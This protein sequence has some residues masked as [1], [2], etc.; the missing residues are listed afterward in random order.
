MKKLIFIFILLLSLFVFAEQDF[1]SMYLDS[2]EN[3]YNGSDAKLVEKFFNILTNYDSN[4]YEPYYYFA[5]TLHNLKQTKDAIPFIGRAVELNPVEETYYLYAKMLFEFDDK[6]FYQ[7]INTALSAYPVSEN[8][9]ALKLDY[10]NSKNMVDSAYSYA[11]FI[12][13]RIPNDRGALY[14]L[15]KYESKMENYTLAVSYLTQ[16]LSLKEPKNEDYLLAGKIYTASKN[17]IAANKSYLKLIASPYR[18]YSLHKLSDNYFT[19]ES[20]DSTLVMLDSLVKHYPDSVSPYGKMLAVFSKTKSEALLESLFIRISKNNISDSTLLDNLSQQ[21]FKYDKFNQAIE[22]YERLSEKYPAYCSKEF[23]QSY[24]FIK[25]YE[26]S[27]KILSV[28]PLK[29]KVDSLFVFKYS[30]LNFF[31]QGKMDSSEF[32][33]ERA[34]LLNDKDTILIKNLANAYSINQKMIKLTELVESIKETFPVL[35]EALK[36]K[37]FKIQE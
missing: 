19:I 2:M 21:L 20:Y 28:Y 26:S 23:I 3:A 35:S 14:A 18:Y 32:Y 34:Y 24:F 33:F 5:S 10:F 4:R 25:D 12:K 22:L 31:K 1:F 27:Q 11:L 36:S 8:L 13:K 15:A 29:T 30:G 16:L 17:Y 9:N 37:Y 6:L 7:T